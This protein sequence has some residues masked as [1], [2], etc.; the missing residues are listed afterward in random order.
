MIR[1][2]ARF[3]FVVVAVVALTG[4]GALL[5]QLPPEAVLL[6]KVKIAET[7][8]PNQI[9]PV[10]LEPRPVQRFLLKVSAPNPE[11]LDNDV[12]RLLRRNRATFELRAL[13]ETELSYDVALPYDLSTAKISNAIGALNGGAVTAVLWEEKKD[14]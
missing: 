9:D 7:I 3:C 2:L 8:K 13:S 6:D 10:T 1:R 12:E 14:D 11:G 5:A 4:G